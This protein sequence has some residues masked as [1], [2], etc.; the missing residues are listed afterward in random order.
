MAD[1]TTC[2]LPST[3]G[4]SCLAHKYLQVINVEQYGDK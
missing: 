4:Q 3:E 2:G 1:T